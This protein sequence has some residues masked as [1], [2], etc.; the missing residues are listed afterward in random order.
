MDRYY[1]YVRITSRW[2]ALLTLVSLLLAGCSSPVPKPSSDSTPPA[3]R[4]HV[5]NKADNSTKDI[6]GSGTLNAQNGDFFVVT[7]FAEDPQ[8]IHKIG[9]S[10]DASWKCSN[11]STAQSE[12]PSL[13]GRNSNTLQPDS[14]N[15]VVTSTFLME[16][17]SIGPFDCPAGF[18]FSGGNVTFAGRGEN[19]FNGTAQATLV[20][21]VTP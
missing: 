1:K 20:F 14:Q 2:L 5:I 21:N 7:L 11:G 13:G 4:W 12:G 9:V 17:A 19:Y 18:T 10:W 6:S 8:G 3:L 16:N 15:N